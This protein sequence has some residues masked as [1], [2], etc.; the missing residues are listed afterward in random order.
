MRSTQKRK[1]LC[2]CQSKGA[3]RAR[4]YLQP[5]QRVGAQQ[6]GL[7]RGMHA[8]VQRGASRHLS[9]QR[10]QRGRLGGALR[11]PGERN[12]E[13]QEVGIALRHSFKRGPR[14]AGGG[15]AVGG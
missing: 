8:A 2:P 10:A 1:L 11:G 6:K 12:P 7:D 13:R 15:I 4:A 9:I 3:T 14:G 5:A